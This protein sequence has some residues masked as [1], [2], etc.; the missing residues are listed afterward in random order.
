LILN[1]E[2][3]GFTLIELMIS[4]AILATL[5]AG[6]SLWLGNYKRSADLESSSK[7]IISSL[8]SAQTR[9]LSGK[10][11]KNWGVYFDNINNK[12]ES[13]SDDG[14]VKTPVE[15]NYLPETLKIDADSISGG[16]NEIIFTRPNGETARDCTIRIENSI[17]QNAYKDISI[18]TSG[19]VGIDQ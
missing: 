5:A 1:T 11:S 2:K 7:I 9:A 10:D 8:R 6:A 4:I 12:I 14:T 16:C 18:K 3:H 19:F 15:E 17:D 13:L